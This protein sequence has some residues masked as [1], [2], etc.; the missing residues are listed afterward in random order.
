[1]ISEVL[2][3]DRPAMNG[4]LFEVVERKGLGHPDTICDLVAERVSYDLGQY[5]LKTCG[6][7]LHYNVDKALLAGG[8]SKPRFGGGELV[9]SPRFYLGDRAV[10]FFDGRNLELDE[11]IQ[12][13][14]SSWLNE[15]LRFLRLGENLVWKNEIKQGSATLNAVEDRGV[16]NDTSAGVGYWPPSDLEEMTLSVERHMNS[17]A[18]KARHPE[19]GEDIKAMSIRRGKDVEIVLACAMVD[20]FIADV[21]DYMEKKASV[22]SD[23][24]SF[25]KSEYSDQYRLSLTMNALDDP[26]QKQDGIYLTVTG[27]SCE[28]GDSGQVGRGNRVS[29]LISFMRPQSMEAW[30]GKNFKTHVGKI[31]NFAAQSLARIITEN[32][33]EAGEATVT[34]VGKIGFPV[35]QPPYI[36]TDIRTKAAHDL[37][38]REKAQ[39]V[40]NAA[41]DAGTIFQPEFLFSEIPP[42]LMQDKKEKRP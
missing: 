17:P 28:S 8:A 22:V 20:K 6:R 34:L 13:S 21:P 2:V 31:Y 38:I 18:F 42:H 24:R 12:A 33:P 29:G 15:N 7:V 23:V 11:V 36:F 35:H 41:I 26:S 37:K 32:V 25:L 30:A 1:M 10:S 9:E 16:S 3:N 40:L 5:Y 19:T 39:T 4:A 14:I 27:L